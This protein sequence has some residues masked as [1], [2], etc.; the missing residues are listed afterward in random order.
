MAADLPEIVLDLGN[1][2]VVC[3]V[4]RGGARRKRLCLRI[5][6][7]GQVEVLLPPK[8]K[9]AQ[10]QRF[11]LQQIDWLRE[12]LRT[13]PEPQAR[14][15]LETG[16]LIP[17]MGQDYALQLSQAVRGQRGVFI[18]DDSLHVRLFEPS[19]ASIRRALISFY[20]KEAMPI[21]EARV[22]HF[23]ALMPWVKTLPPVSCRMMTSRWGSCSVRGTISLN[24]R[25]IMTPIELVDYVVAHELCHIKEHNHSARYYALLDEAMP[26]W[27]L[28]RE[29][30]KA[31]APRVMGF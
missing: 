24:T 4:K 5:R 15:S 11:V 25:L 2:S 6:P 29:K 8:V 23:S 7:D 20:A 1:K 13:M 14:N 26:D 9:A 31:L 12:R 21:F 18:A 28:R 16:A 30:L 10:A 17:F 27:R 19:P 3:H 22:A